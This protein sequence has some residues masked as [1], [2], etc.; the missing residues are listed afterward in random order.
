MDVHWMHEALQQAN[1]GR[2]LSPPNP[3]VGCV[4]VKDN[5]AVGYGHTQPPG[6]AHAE[7]IALKQAGEAAQSATAFVTLEPCC[8]WGKTPPCVDAIVQAGIERVVV[9]TEDPDNLVAGKG[10]AHLRSKG[11]QVDVGILREQ[12]QDQLKAYIFHRTHNRPYC[13]LKSAVSI[14]GKVAAADGTSQWITDESARIHA[15][16]QR[17]QSQAIMVGAGTANI[18]QPRLTVRG[19]D[20]PHTLPLRVICDAHGKVPAMG[21]LF[22]TT[23]QRTLIYTTERCPS[24]VMQKWQD[25][26]VETFVVPYENGVSLH[27]VLKDLAARGVLQ[28]LVEGGPTLHTAFIEQKLAQELLLYIGNCLLG[29]NGQPFYHGQISTLPQA[30]RM[31]LK[32]CR[33]FTDSACLMWQI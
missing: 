29:S 16:E 22:D 33:P 24:D 30:P 6:Q 10:I 26:G 25:K 2:L 17:A 15:H 5:K 23:L 32:D 20:L 12:V 3:W 18:D 31:R 8:H 7:I 28:L 9:G 13:I 27:A 11:I 1:K 14:D 21:P 19:V 4:I